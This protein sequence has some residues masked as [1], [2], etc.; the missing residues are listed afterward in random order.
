MNRSFLVLLVV[1]F[2]LAVPVSAREVHAGDRREPGVV[3]VV[4]HLKRL[5]GVKT[6]SDWPTPPIPVPGPPS[7]P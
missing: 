6:N 1:L 5:L 4:R 3:K 2:L 7:K